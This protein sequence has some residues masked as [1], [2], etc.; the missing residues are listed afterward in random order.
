MRCVRQKL[1]GGPALD[2]R[3][4]DLITDMGEAEQKAGGHEQRENAQRDQ[5]SSTFRIGLVGL[6]VCSH[7]E[8]EVLF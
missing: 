6:G 7:G 4:R 5:I 1:G 8:Y 2:C 3:C